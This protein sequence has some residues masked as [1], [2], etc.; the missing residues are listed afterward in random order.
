MKVHPFKIPKPVHERLVVQVDKAPVFYDKLHQHEEIQISGMM[1]G[2]GKLVVADSVHPYAPGDVFVIGKYCPHVF[3]G[4][5]GFGKSHMIS[6]FFTAH[7]F[8]EHFFDIPEMELLAGFFDSAEAGFR[9]KSNDKRE[10]LLLREMAEADKFQRFLLFLRLLEHLSSATPQVLTG[11]VY[12]KKISVNEGSRM[13][14]IFDHVMTNFQKEITL[15]SVA[16]MAC[17][18]PS[19]FCR[20]F[21][22]RTNKTFFQFLIELRIEHACQLLSARTTLPIAEIAAISGFGSISNFNRKFKKM[23]GLTPMEYFRKLNKT[24]V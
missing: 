16:D 20:F 13:Q 21:K 8:G 2:E 14:T 6:V 5:P 9:V 15:K 4:I 22:L 11:F 24:G 17:M 1:A 10:I 3:L 18:T 23:K 12:P 19:A 7:S